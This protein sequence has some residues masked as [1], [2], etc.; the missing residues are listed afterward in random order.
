MFDPFL[1]LVEQELVKTLSIEN[2]LKVFEVLE[3]FPKSE[4]LKDVC[5][6]IKQNTLLILQHESF[7]QTRRSVV[8]WIL[9]QPKL[10][11]AEIQ[12]FDAGF[13][14]AKAECARNGIENAKPEELRKTLGEE[15]FLIRIPT[16]SPRHFMKGPAASGIF[17]LKESNEIVDYIVASTKTNST[18]DFVSRFELEGRKQMTYFTFHYDKKVN[19][20]SLSSSPIEITTTLNF[21]SSSDILLTGFCLC[22]IIDTFTIASVVLLEGLSSVFYEEKMNLNQLYGREGNK[23]SSYSFNWATPILISANLA[24]KLSVT[25]GFAEVQDTI[26]KLN[27]EKFTVKYEREFFENPISLEMSTTSPSNIRI[28]ALYIH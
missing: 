22:P 18:K 20:I 11:A 1:K 14:W 21:E 7:T 10:N 19:F 15:L 28:Y 2:V 6:F 3:R 27:T 25:L 4:V 23:S 5:L 16:M 8:N 17:S 24:Y 12:L 13:R 9:S 26:Y